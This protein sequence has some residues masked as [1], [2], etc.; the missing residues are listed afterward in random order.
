MVVY[1]SVYSITLLIADLSPRFYWLP[2][3][4]LVYGCMLLLSTLILSSYSII[5]VIC[6]GAI[7][8]CAW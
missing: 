7:G 6:W 2:K 8:D 3:H 1:S 4:L 5:V